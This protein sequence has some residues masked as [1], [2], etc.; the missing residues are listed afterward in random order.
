MWIETARIAGIG[1]ERQHGEEEAGDD[2]LREGAQHFHEAA[3]EEAQPALRDD[4][5]RREEARQKPS[6][7][8]IRVETSAMLSVSTIL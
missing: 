8:P 6:A 3:H 4:I 2:D 7:K 1:A 5:G